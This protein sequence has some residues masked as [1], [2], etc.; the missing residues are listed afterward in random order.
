MEQLECVRCGERSSGLSLPHCEH[1][2][3][4]RIA[5]DR[6]PVQRG[7]TPAALAAARRA[8]EL[9]GTLA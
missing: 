7:P 6:P 1:S 4:H 2:W 3:G 8:D 5:V 9:F